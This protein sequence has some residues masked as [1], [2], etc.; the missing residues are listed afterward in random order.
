MPTLAPCLDQLR[1]EIDSRWPHRS[2]S[3]DGWIGNAAHAARK[4]DHNPDRH[5]VVH[6]ID[7][8][9]PQTRSGRRMGRVIKRAVI[10]DERAWYVIWRGHIYSKTYGWKRQSYSGPSAHFDHL[11][12]S[13]DYTLVDVLSRK[14]WKVASIWTRLFGR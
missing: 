2:K 1:D 4:S 13:C 7:V 8:T 9:T 10:A 12:I 5:G 6:A 14:P 3:S 11:H